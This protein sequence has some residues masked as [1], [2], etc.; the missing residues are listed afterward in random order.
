MGVKD[1][2][3]NSAIACA[4]FTRLDASAPYRI[5]CGGGD[6]S[7]FTADAFFSGGT[8]STTANSIST[9][10][11]TNPAPAAVYQSERYGDFSYALSGLTPNAAYTMRLHFAEIYWTAAGKRTFNVSINGQ[12]VLSNFDIFA[13]AGGANKAIARDF[14]ASADGSG[15]LIV[16]FTNIIGG[17]KC[18]GIE[19]LSNSSSVKYGSVQKRARNLQTALSQPLRLKQLLSAAQQNGWRI[20]DLQGKR[21]SADRVG[22]RGIYLIEIEGNLS[23]KININ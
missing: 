2:M 1:G 9:S 20:Y 14:A 11:V 5:N 21:R 13:D 4:V 6:E 22:E 19:V 18:S 3:S 17:A 23:K 16:Q 7:P 10:G 8:A 12:Q 15:K